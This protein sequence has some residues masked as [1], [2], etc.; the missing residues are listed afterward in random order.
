MENF[1]DHC[2]GAWRR[3]FLMMLGEEGLPIK[4]LGNKKKLR[5]TAMVSVVYGVSVVYLVSVVCM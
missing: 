4:V 5:I 2:Y 1:L 3:Q